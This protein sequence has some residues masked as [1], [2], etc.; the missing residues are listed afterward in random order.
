[1]LLAA[2]DLGTQTFRAAIAE[3]RE[4]DV[5]PVHSRLFNAR[6]G[7]V[8]W[9]GELTDSTL[10]CIDEIRS[11]LARYAVSRV[12]V[13][14][15]EAMRRLREQYPDQF[16]LLQARLEL[17]I[18]ILPP[19]VEGQLTALG[20]VSALDL[21]GK[22]VRQPFLV[23]DVGGGSTEAILCNEEG[24]TVESMP[25]GAVTFHK[26]SLKSLT[27]LK[28]PPYSEAGTI[29]AT[30]GTAT[31][32]GAMILELTEYTPLK[33]RG[34]CVKVDTIDDWIYRLTSLD[35]EERKT[36]RGLEPERA[37]III[38]GLRILRACLSHLGAPEI[39]ISDGG[40]L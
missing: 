20:A 38:P 21:R 15:T 34:L 4:Q 16:D 30:G 28:A 10:R 24:I 3:I 19:F 12:R 32:L 17:P 40:L 9:T 29:L 14:G 23:L 18:E 7:E 25:I 33:I 22:Q 2:I 1:M 13:C 26:A 11:T 31:T 35:L 27:P 6:L 36:L 8:L 39:T 37:D 5:L